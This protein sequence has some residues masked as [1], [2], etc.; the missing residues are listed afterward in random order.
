MAGNQEQ[1]PR[2]PPVPVMCE[3]VLA[4]QVE[5]EEGVEP[6]PG[7][8]VLPGTVSCSSRLHKKIVFHVMLVDTVDTTSNA[9]FTF[10]KSVD[11]D[12][13]LERHFLLEVSRHKLESSQT[14]VFV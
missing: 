9:P 14:R 6:A 7:G 4:A 8:R 1:L 2:P 12:E 5:P 3:V 11:R 13:I 10:I